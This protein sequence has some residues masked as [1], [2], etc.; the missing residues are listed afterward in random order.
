MPAHL[1]SLT[2]PIVL[3]ENIFPQQLEGALKH[4]SQI[5][6]LPSP[7]RRVCSGLRPFAPAVPSTKNALPSDFPMAVS[8]SFWTLLMSPLPR[9]YPHHS[10]LLYLLPNIHHLLRSYSFLGLAF[11]CSCQYRSGYTASA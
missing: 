3:P 7:H 2:L 6:S 5:P 1:L 4:L 8:F 10:I 11:F 9:G